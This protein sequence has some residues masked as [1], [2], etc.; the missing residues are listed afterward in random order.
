MTNNLVTG[1]C[2]KGIMDISFINC[3]IMIDCMIMLSFAK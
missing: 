3:A 1:K 2:C